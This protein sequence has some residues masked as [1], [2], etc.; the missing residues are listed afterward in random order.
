MCQSQHTR[1]LQLGPQNMGNKLSQLDFPR[2]SSPHPNSSSDSLPRRSRSNSRVPSFEDRFS[3]DTPRTISSTTAVSQDDPYIRFFNVQTSSDVTQGSRVTLQQY[4]V[5]KHLF[6]TNYMGVT[7]DQLARGIRV[8]DSAIGTGIW[9]MEMQRDF[10]ASQFFG[11]DLAVSLWPDTQLLK[12]GQR[13]RIVGGESL[14]ALPFE[15]GFF[16]Y[17]HEQTHLFVTHRDTMPKVI[18]EFARVL[19]PGGYIDIVELD[20]LP[21]V[22]PSPLVG[23][24]IKR[25]EKRMGFG[26]FDLRRAAQVAQYIEQSGFFTDIQV[27]R[28][29]MP[30]GWDGA[31]G[32]LFRIHMRDSH[33]AL[34]TVIGMSMNADQSIPSEKEFERFTEVFLNDCA[35][36][37]AY[38]NA[39]RITARR[40]TLV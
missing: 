25:A 37:Q 40:K 28:R 5:L 21:A 3:T 24:F 38:C 33:M 6:Q 4:A 15:N 12:I 29:S 34:R 36:G 8:L 26:G 18:S 35:D 7:A 32:D 39:Y 1:T 30:V 14:G 9:I 10:P 20:P 17:V 11:L 27:V 31:L 19:K 16:D 13:T 2:R 22:V 23:T